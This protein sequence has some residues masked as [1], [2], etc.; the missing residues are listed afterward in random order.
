MSTSPAPGL[1]TDKNV[2]P[3]EDPEK[4]FAVGRLA[5]LVWKESGM[6]GVILVS[7]KKARQKPCLR[8]GYSLLRIAGAKNCPECGLA[9]RVSLAGNSALEW[10]N[11]RWQ[12][13]IALGFAVLALGMGCKLVNAGLYWVEYW[14]DE[15]Y[16]QLREATYAAVQWVGRYCGEASLILCG[17]G[18]CLLV[19][20]EGRHPDRTRVLHGVSL[21]AGIGVIALGVA[22]V[23]MGHGYLWSRWSI[24]VVWQLGMAGP[25]VPIVVSILV[26]LFGL[27]IGKRGRSRLLRQ[28]CQ[29]P[30]WPAGVGLVVWV[31]DLNR[32]WWPF[33]S[34]VLNVAFPL[35]MIGALGV[36]VKVLRV[37]A[38]E[39]EVNWVTDE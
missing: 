37:G 18:L 17:V 32:V 23:L 14:Y 35:A 11:P 31:L 29:A 27:E 12:R 16:L 22:N 8:C 15:D 3:T 38:R 2:C 28:L 1:A 20:G 36:M 9:V 24:Y 39:A 21:G 6:R 13:V 10:S 19:K 33:S 30:L 7:D 25:W 26:C 34:V 5:S 4:H